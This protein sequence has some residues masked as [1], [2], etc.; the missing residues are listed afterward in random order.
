MSQITIN[1][2]ELY[3][4]DNATNES[5]V[6]NCSYYVSNNSPSWLIIADSIEECIEYMIENFDCCPDPDDEI[7]ED[8]IELIQSYYSAK[9]LTPFTKYNHNQ[10]GLEETEC[11][12]V[13]YILDHGGDTVSI[14][15]YIEILELVEN[16]SSDGS[17][18]HSDLCREFRLIY[19]DDIEQIYQDYIEEMVK[20]CY[21][22]SYELPSFLEIDWEQ[23]AKNCLV[24]G[25]GHSFSGYDGSEEYI[26]S[27]YI[28]C[29]N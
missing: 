13:D 25:Y 6:F 14:E 1:Q 19:D 18:E 29:T 23:T 16:A 5:T 26:N 7:E 21:L 4:H 9:E 11:S 15:V 10:L 8:E 24:D 22:S 12:I 3:T 27:T 17:I 20:D 2:T 28:F